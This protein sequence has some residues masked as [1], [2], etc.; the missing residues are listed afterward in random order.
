MCT[1]VF[2]ECTESN[3]TRTHRVLPE[4]ALGS[5]ITIVETKRECPKCRSARYPRILSSSS[6]FSFGAIWRYY[7][8]ACLRRRMGIFINAIPTRQHGRNAKV[9]RRLIARLL[10][11]RLSVAYTYRYRYC[12][13]MFAYT[14]LD[15]LSA[16]AS[17]R[18]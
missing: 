11:T 1:G 10:V 13:R 7:R 9:A 8:R 17:L 18:P 6:Y 14:A 15:R 2:T 5:L 12:A 3:A 16:L 4:R